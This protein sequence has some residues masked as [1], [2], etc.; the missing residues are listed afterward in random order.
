VADTVRQ[1]NQPDTVVLRKYSPMFG[2]TGWPW[3]RF[4]RPAN[5]FRLQ[6]TFGYD[7]RAVERLPYYDKFWPRHK[8]SLNRC[9]WTC[10]RDIKDIPRTVSLARFAYSTFW[11][12]E[13]NSSQCYLWSNIVM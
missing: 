1:A 5:R 8:F 12:A 13:R 4:P 6:R 2:W 7:L 9:S 10:V 11:Y 3:V